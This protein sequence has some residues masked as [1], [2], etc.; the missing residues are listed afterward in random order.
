MEQ[1]SYRVPDRKKVVVT[2]VAYTCMRKI[3][4]YFF[5]RLILYMYVLV[6]K[7]PMKLALSYMTYKCISTHYDTAR[8]KG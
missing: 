1:D 5:N 2:E 7:V 8:L 6:T 4:Y 3:I